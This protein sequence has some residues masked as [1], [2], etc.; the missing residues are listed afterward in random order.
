MNE[1]KTI[2][3]IYKAYQN[4]FFG[5]NI[6]EISL[7]KKVKMINRKNILEKQKF[8]HQS[9]KE[10]LEGKNLKKRIQQPKIFEENKTNKKVKKIINKERSKSKLYFNKIKSLETLFGSKY[11]KK[12]QK[13][14]LKKII[15][16]FLEIN[17]I[18]KSTGV[19]LLKNNKVSNVLDIKKLFHTEFIQNNIFK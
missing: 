1:R 16:Y 15:L 2:R 5:N 13:E 9:E 12:F 18:D 8:F 17:E 11:Q 3:K 6:E 14:I 19:K 7:E 4:D 10:I